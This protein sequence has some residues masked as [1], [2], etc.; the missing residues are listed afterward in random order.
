M[1]RENDSFQ[2]QLVSFF[3]LFLFLGSDRI[4]LVII[5]YT[6]LKIYVN[7]SKCIHQ[8]SNLGIF[9]FL[10][11]V[12]MNDKKEDWL[13]MNSIQFNWIEL[14]E[15]RDMIKKCSLLR[16]YLLILC[17]FVL[18]ISIFLSLSHY[19]D[20]YIYRRSKYI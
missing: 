14:N 13:D 15:R 17:L 19:N 1:R 6:V 11:F 20:G 18:F 2:L 8:L 12:L 10:H 3:P 7:K 4:G 5:K 9:S 16:T